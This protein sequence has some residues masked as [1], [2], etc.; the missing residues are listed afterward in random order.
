MLSI[1]STLE[2]VVIDDQLTSLEA[3][4]LQQAYINKVFVRFYLDQA[5]TVNTPIKETALF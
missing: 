3:A 4:F 1:P 2:V 5:Y